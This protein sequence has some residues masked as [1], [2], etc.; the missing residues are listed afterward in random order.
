MKIRRVDVRYAHEFGPRVV[1]IELDGGISV[2]GPDRALNS[3]ELNYKTRGIC[4]QPF[5]HTV[6]EYVKNLDAR[7]LRNLRGRNGPMA[8]EIQKASATFKKTNGK[9]ISN[10]PILMYGR[11]ST[12][13]DSAEQT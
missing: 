10:C 13:K 5:D 11:S 8:A 3:S 6:F 12:Y 7:R 2:S 4:W 1:A 9:K